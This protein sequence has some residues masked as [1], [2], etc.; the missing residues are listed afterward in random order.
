MSNIEKTGENLSPLEY[1]I[2][3]SME[4][5]LKGRTMAAKM[6]DVQ[7]IE[8]IAE[9]HDGWRFY[10]GYSGRCMFGDRCPGIVCPSGEASQVESVVRKSGIKAKASRDNL[11]RSLIVY[12][13]GISSQRS[14]LD[15]PPS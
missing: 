11:G 13:S 12:W 6:T 2:M 9:R 8:R 4:T 14:G 5:N 10:D 3:W 1:S 15:C 7:K